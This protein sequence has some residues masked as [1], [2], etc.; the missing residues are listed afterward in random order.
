MTCHCKSSVWMKPPFSGNRYLKGLSSIRR[1]NKCQV[2]EVCVSTL[3]DCVTMK[4]R[5]DTFLR[6]YPRQAS[7]DCRTKLFS[8]EHTCILICWCALC[9]FCIN[10]CPYWWHHRVSVTQNPDSKSIQVLYAYLIRLLCGGIVSASSEFCAPVSLSLSLCFSLS[11]GGVICRYSFIH[12]SFSIHLHILQGEKY[13]FCVCS[14]RFF[15]SSPGNLKSLK[16]T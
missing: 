6:T 1:P 5:N 7:H 15:P 9:H 11:E 16:T 3:Y 13:H 14:S 8:H 2:S 12:S 10:V 4:S